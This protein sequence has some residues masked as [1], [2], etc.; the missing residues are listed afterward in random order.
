MTKTTKSTGAKKAHIIYEGKPKRKGGLVISIISLIIIILALFLVSNGTFFFLEKPIW[1]ISGETEMTSDVIVTVNGEEI[2]T[3]ELDAQWGALPLETKMTITRTDVLDR[4]VEERL[5][6]QQ[7][8]LANIS[9]TDEEV[10]IFVNEQ[11]MTLGIT[12]EVFVEYLK[13]QNITL[14]EVSEIYKQQ[15]IIIK[16]FDE[17]IGA[18]IT[19]TQEEVD[20]YYEQYKNDFFQE[21]M[22]TVRH[23]LIEI[24]ENFNES[25]AQERVSEV[26]DLLEDNF[27][28]FCEL[29]AN[30]S[31]DL[32]STQTCGEYTFSMGQFNNPAFEDPAFAMGVN[33]VQVVNTMF[34]LHIMLKVAEIP[35]MQLGLDDEILMLPDKPLLQTL[36]E[37]AIKEQKAQETYDEYV[38]TII[39]T[40][41][42][43]YEVIEIEEAPELEL[44]DILELVEEESEEVEPV[45]TETEVVEEEE[46]IEVVNAT[47]MNITDANT[48]AVNVTSTN[49]MSVNATDV[50]TT[51]T[52]ATGVNETEDETAAEVLII[53]LEST[54][55]NSS[56][57][58]NAS[59]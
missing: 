44:E 31:M 47:D 22:V 37:D 32:G 27:S 4:M 36:V 54:T 14:E 41:D 13:A 25:Q 46:V 19:V 29:V 16:L 40:S 34:G 21:E 1:G 49:T 45:V 35:E 6:L 9:V 26:L 59:A 11:L 28:N 30:Y 5:L 10:E 43:I 42:I 39:A 24:N 58:T 53:P 7:A 48:T 52:N 20:E 15:L 57:V 51:D 8:K 38:A 50:N 55:A 56:N 33:E 18:N 2:Y 23:I 12:P 3:S 17:K